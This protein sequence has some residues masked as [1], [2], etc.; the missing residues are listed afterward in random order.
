MGYKKA[1]E[2]FNVSR[3]TLK[4]YVKTSD[5]PIEDI[6]SGKMERKPVLPPEL[7]EEMVSY[8]LQMEINYYSVTASDLKR[9]SFQLAIRN[10]IPNPFS[11]TKN[12][13]DKKFM[14]L[15]SSS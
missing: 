5:K 8:Y 12:T 3:A 10:N 4:D 9:I 2:L 7:E 14:K 6:V 15:I 1:V 13:A 11:R